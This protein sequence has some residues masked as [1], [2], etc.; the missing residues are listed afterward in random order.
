MSV[1][2]RGSVVQ[3]L[4]ARLGSRALHLRAHAFPQ[5]R[6]RP[7]QP[8]RDDR[9]RSLAD[10]GHAL[11]AR[12]AGAARRAPHSSR[13]RDLAD[14][15]H[16]KLALAALAV[17]ADRVRLRH[18]APSFPAYRRHAHHRR[19]VRHRHELPLR[20]GANL[21]GHHA[22]PDGAS[23][24]RLGAW[25]HRPA[26]LAEAR[27]RI[28]T[29]S[30]AALLARAAH[31]VCGARR[32][33]DA[34]ARAHGRSRGARAIRGAEAP[35]CARPRR[36]RNKRSRCGATRRGSPSTLPVAGLLLLIGGTLWWRRRRAGGVIVTYLDGPTVQ[37]LGRRDLARDQPQPRHSACLRL[38][39]QSALLDLPRARPRAFAAAARRSARPRRAR[40]APSARRP[41]FAS[42]ANGDLPARSWW[43]A[44]CSRSPARLSPRNARRTIRASTPRRRCSSSIFAASRR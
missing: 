44:S 18:S 43:R 15:R 27:A 10:R 39:R 16:A 25:L 12:H 34:G 31:P 5:S 42:L 40:C 8:R 29:A 14:R 4:Q 28:R 7:R 19:H 38:R 36:R 9:R 20:A 3:R 33:D 41:T 22:G 11:G 1:L 13:A 2:W 30:H 32:R 35:R 17:D 21:A 23:P 24:H 6:G 37:G 26:F